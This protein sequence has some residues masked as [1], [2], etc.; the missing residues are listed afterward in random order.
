M[1]KKDI[2]GIVLTK[3]YCAYIRDL[4]MAVLSDLHI[5]YEEVMAQKG[6]FLPK[7]QK[8]RIINVLEN[9]IDNIRP[10]RIL[11]DG[12]FKHEFSGNV[13]QEWDEIIEIIDFIK[14]RADLIVVRGNHDNFLKN[15]LK[16][17][18]IPLHRSY[19]EGKYTFNHGDK[20]IEYDGFLIM[21][22]E[23][24]SIKIRDPTGG[25]ITIPSFLYNEK[26]LVLPSPS[27]YSS[28]SDIL[29]G[30][31]LSPILKKEDPYSFNALGI[32]DKIGLLDIGNL[33]NLITF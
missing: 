20:E 10:S 5:G 11:V 33:R 24:P 1:E 19:R 6:L 25:I 27:I 28:G 26:I 7:F 18:N 14:E 30:D 23:H 15:I 29:A 13:K 2:D 32:D 21:G 22:H 16:K 9:I 17:Y 31:I 3:Y 4:D 12:D 8:K